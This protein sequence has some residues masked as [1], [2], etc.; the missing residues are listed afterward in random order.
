MG[1]ALSEKDL[2]SIAQFM[3]ASARE[4][5]AEV[6]ED[7]A[8]EVHRQADLARLR[9]EADGLL[10]QMADFE[11][12]YRMGFE[13]FAASL[14]PTLGSEQH[15]DYLAWSKLAERYRLITEALARA[16]RRCGGKGER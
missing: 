12:K 13:E 2:T 5:E 10:A 7:L 9:Q 1:R 16:Q 8:V 3:H 4:P 14:S 6:D 11:A 15:A